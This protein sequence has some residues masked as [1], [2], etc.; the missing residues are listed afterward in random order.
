MRYHLSIRTAPHQSYHSPSGWEWDTL[1]LA[2]AGA[3]RADRLWMTVILIDTLTGKSI[4]FSPA[5]VLKQTAGLSS[6]S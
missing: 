2:I 6:R 3:R 5:P 4:P 1:P